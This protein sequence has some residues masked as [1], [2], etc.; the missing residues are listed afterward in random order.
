S[1]KP[2]SHVDLEQAFDFPCAIS[3]LAVG[4]RL[5]GLFNAQPCDICISILRN[6]LA[7]SKLIEWI[8]VFLLSKAGYYASRILT[9]ARGCARVASAATPGLTRTCVR[10]HS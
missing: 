7:A 10:L 9:A 1:A 5:I 3:I 8:Y 4:V 6:M 2:K